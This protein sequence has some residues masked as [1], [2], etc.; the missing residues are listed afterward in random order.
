MFKYLSVF[1]LFV[2]F[3][4][5]AQVILKGNPIACQAKLEQGHLNSES[6]EEVFKIEQFITKGNFVRKKICDPRLFNL[7]DANK[8][9][10][11]YDQ[12]ILEELG[13]HPNGNF[14]EMKE[15]IEI[16]GRQAKFM[17]IIHGVTCN[18]NKAYLFFDKNGDF[19]SFYD[20]ARF[21]LKKQSHFHLTS[22]DK[23]KMV[24]L[25][26]NSNQFLNRFN[27]EV[28]DKGFFE[29][30][31]WLREENIILGTTQTITDGMFLP[32]KFEVFKTN[33]DHEKKI[34]SFVRMALFSNA[35]IQHY[36]TQTSSFIKK[37]AFQ[38]YSPGNKTEKCP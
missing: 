8:V 9:F 7:C 20:D 35:L 16:D 3:K 37:G 10:F 18:G 12:T 22:E 25:S 23:D 26:T 33:S 5:S 28:G 31:K 32:D 29:Q 2:F 36:S 14:I 17:R 34:G 38:N 11:E 27:S 19:I 1:L 4:S 15:S 24:K 6:L 13:C 21:Q 30:E